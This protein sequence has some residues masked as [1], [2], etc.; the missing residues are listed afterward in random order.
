MRRRFDGLLVRLDDIRFR[1]WDCG[2]WLP[3]KVGFFAEFNPFPPL[4]VP[5]LCAVRPK[6]TPL[7]PLRQSKGPPDCSG[8]PY[9][10]SNLAAQ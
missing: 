2:H 3:S 1:R 10:I 9:H 8:G 6:G 7:W 5:R 4:F